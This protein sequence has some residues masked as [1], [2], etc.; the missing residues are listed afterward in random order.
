MALD[1]ETG[2]GVSGAVSFVTVAELDAYAAQRGITLPADEAQKERLLLDAAEYLESFAHRY[3]GRRYSR[4][5]GLAWPR[6]GAVDSDG[7]S[8]AWDEVPDVVKRAQLILAVEAMTTTLM[9]TVEAGAQAVIAESIPGAVS[10]TY[11]TPEEG[12]G[13]SPHVTR[14]LAVLRGVLRSGRT[15]IVTRG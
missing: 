6:V 3:V 7:F 9:P 13:P 11:A 4:E 8:Y 14:A 5:Q 12:G 15:A 2:S 1:I 10:V